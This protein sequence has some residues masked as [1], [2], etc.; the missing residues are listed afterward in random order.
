[1]NV[2]PLR[3]TFYHLVLISAARSHLQVIRANPISSAGENDSRYYRRDVDDLHECEQGVVSKD[4]VA[5]QQRPGNKP[6]DPRGNANAP[7][8]F[9]NIEMAYLRDIGDDD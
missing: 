7:G 5:K 1:M 6:D 2:F 3:C 4:A 8:A 9:L